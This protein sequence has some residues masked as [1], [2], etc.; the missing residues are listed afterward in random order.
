MGFN[1][2]QFLWLSSLSGLTVAGFG[3]QR[4]ILTASTGTVG[5]QD[6]KNFAIASRPPSELLFRFVA[7]ADTGTGEKGQYAIANAMVR[8]HQNYPFNVVILGGDNIY[9]KGEIERIN[10]VFEKPYK[11]L[12]DN[13]VKFYAALGNHDIATENGNQEV[14]YPYFNMQG[15]YYTFSYEPI[16]FFILDA[17]SNADWDQQMPWLEDQL[18]R[19][20]AP[21]KVVVSHYQLYSSG[22]YGVNEKLIN[23]FSSLLNQYKVQLYINGHEHHYE[24]TTPIQ[25]TTYLTCGAGSMT[26]PVQQSSWTATSASM[27]SFAAI[28]IYKDQMLIQGINQDNKVF[29]RGTILI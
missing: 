7:V 6:V 21:W 22:V 19:S 24:R 18:S 27:L 16:Q 13:N 11:P 2:R 4:R 12:L 14:M 25:G 3:I 29:D 28:E 17:N 15:R 9:P 23:R 10:D 20:Q 8:H 26:R 5:N 1:R